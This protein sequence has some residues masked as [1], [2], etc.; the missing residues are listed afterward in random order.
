MNVTNDLSSPDSVQPVNAGNVPWLAAM[1]HY[2]PTHLAPETWTFWSTPVRDLVSACFTEAEAHMAAGALSECIALSEVAPGTSMTEVVSDSNVWLVVSAMKRRGCGQR[3]C[4]NAAAVLR[5]MQ[6]R[7]RGISDETGIASPKQGSAITG[8]IEMLEDLVAG[9]SLPS[10]LHDGLALILHDLSEPKH[11]PWGTPMSAAEF[12][13]I[14]RRVGAAAGQPMPTWPTLRSEALVRA[15]G[16]PQPMV[17]VLARLELDLNTLK[18][19]TK[20][21]LDVPDVGSAMRGCETVL[22]TLPTVDEELPMNPTNAADPVTKPSAPAPIAAGGA[23]R[24][25]VSRAAA[26]RATEQF[27]TERQAPPPPL[28][29]D[30]EEWLATWTPAGLTADEWALVQPLTHDLLRRSGIKGTESIKK[31]ARALATHL[32]FCAQHGYTLTGAEVMTGAAIDNST[33]NG[34]K[35]ARDSN[36][37]TARSLLRRLATTLQASDEAP[38]RVQSIPHWDVKPPYSQH[39]MERIV[40]LTDLPADAAVRRRTKAAVAL[41]AGAGLDLRDLRTMTRAHVDD[42]GSEGI[43]LTVPSDRQRQVWLRAAYEEM[44]REGISGL[45]AN[46]CLL[47]R[48]SLYKGSLVNIYERIQPVGED[49]RV[50]QG[51]LRNTWLVTLMCEPIPLWSILRAAGLE[52]PRTLADLS[53]YLRRAS[54]RDADQILRGAA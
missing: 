35:S 37:A 18:K 39:E 14:R 17:D 8:G 26:R 6:R 11:H 16:Q 53:S 34:L 36:R 4:R 47:G 21:V 13:S 41:G 51:R 1:R 3:S 23:R 45:T 28:S 29:P 44:L 50:Q 54:G 32:T 43:L 27:L 2:T 52:S 48:D 42:R 19:L 7:V 25:K 40:R 10:D 46:E 5:R 22:S 30:Q 12:T 31:Y 9:Q 15:L 20:Q 49:L 24:R 38:V 33:R